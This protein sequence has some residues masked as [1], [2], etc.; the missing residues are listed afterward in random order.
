MS[1]SAAVQIRLRTAGRSLPVSQLA[2][3]WLIL[4]DPADLP[5]GPGTVH[6]IVDGAP[7]ET[8]VLIEATLPGS[9]RVSFRE[10]PEPVPH[11]HAGD[12]HGFPCRACCAWVGPYG[13]PHLQ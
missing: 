3:D 10:T 2:P 12:G 1:H 6:L 7:K 11:D 9:A 5:T 8:S 13:C 4:T